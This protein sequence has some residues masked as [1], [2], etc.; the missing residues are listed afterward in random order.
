MAAVVATDDREGM[1][2]LATIRTLF[3]F[4]AWATGKILEQAGRLTPEQYA[5]RTGPYGQS[6]QQILTHMLI[7]QHLWRVR[8]ETGQTAVSIGPDDFPTVAAYRAGWE[9][10]RRSL[11]AYVAGLDDDAPTRTIRFERR[12]ETYAYTLWHILFQ[13]IGHSTQHRAELAERL[14][15]FGYSPGDLDFF[16]WVPAADV[17]RE[18]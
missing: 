10:E 9:A 12:G 16:L 11:D 6:M 4:D 3:D 18:A 15:A 7:A 1:M 14:T 17:R 2:Q 8:C 13:V 5:E